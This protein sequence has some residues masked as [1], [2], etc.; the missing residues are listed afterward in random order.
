MLCQDC[1]QKVATVVL[2]EIREGTKE[3]RHLCTGCVEA[4][5]IQ[6]PAVRNPL[7]HDVLFRSLLEDA[8]LDNTPLGEHD[9]DA[10]VCPACGW[11][12]VQFRETGMLGCPE[13]YAAFEAELEPLVR[14]L[15]GAAEHLGR[16]YRPSERREDERGD[17]EGIRAELDKAVEREE[18]ERAAV[19]RDRLH[20]LEQGKG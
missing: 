7:Q 4:R 3:V 2:T 15:H 11:A 1:R 13:C 9:A 14:R 17:L 16:D 10:E 8:S 6:T 18:F 5:G 12:Y 19:L 20:R